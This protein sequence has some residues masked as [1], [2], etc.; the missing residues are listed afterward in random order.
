[1]P[2]SECTSAYCGPVPSVANLRFRYQ[3]AP[4]PK[5]N[6][7]KA[8]DWADFIKRTT[9]LFTQDS[10]RYTGMVQDLLEVFAEDNANVAENLD[11]IMRVAAEDVDWSLPS[12][13]HAIPN[14][15]GTYLYDTLLARIGWVSV[16][17]A[18]KD[19]QAELHNLELTHDRAT[20][21][22][23]TGS[24]SEQVHK[25]PVIHVILT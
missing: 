4:L 15:R 23:A 8:S 3:N 14:S 1:M 2:T 13:Y 19:K 6:K 10:R 7:R 12:A 16:G 11:Y 17:E 18:L 21:Q 25:V 22:V 24:A 9:E 20:H 5:K